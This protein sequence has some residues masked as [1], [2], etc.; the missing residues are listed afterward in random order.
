MNSIGKSLNDTERGFAT[1]NLEQLLSNLFLIKICR[2]KVWTFKFGGFFCQFIDEHKSNREYHGTIVAPLASSFTSRGELF[3]LRN[4][5]F[6]FLLVSSV[7]NPFWFFLNI[8]YPFIPSLLILASLHLDITRLSPS[9]GTNRLQSLLQ[10]AEK[11]WL[12]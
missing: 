3:L 11:P 4:C 9:P 10:S 6:C 12:L 1:G 5:H 7:D 2:V 8:E